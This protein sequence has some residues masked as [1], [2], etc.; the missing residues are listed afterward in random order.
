MRLDYVLITI[1]LSVKSS[2]RDKTDGF[3]PFF[4]EYSY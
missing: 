3:D 1:E 2:K 4:E